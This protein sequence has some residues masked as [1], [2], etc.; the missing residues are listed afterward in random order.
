MKQIRHLLITGIIVAGLT[1][2]IGILLQMVIDRMPLGGSVQADNIESLLLKHFWAIAFLFALIVGIMLYSIFAFRQ[3]KGE[4]E[5]GDYLEGNTPLELVWTIVPTGVVIWFAFLGGQSLTLMEAV[6]RD[7]LRV[8]VTARQWSWS[9]EYPEHG[10]TSDVLVLPI[11]DQTL[12]R[13]R[14][15]DVVHSFWVPEFGPKQD[16]LP[17]GE[18]RELRINPTVAGEYTLACAELCGRQHALMLARVEVMSRT[19][20]DAWVEMKVA[21]D[22]CALGDQVGCGQKLSQESG[23]Q[24]CHTVDGSP[25]VGPTWLGLYETEE[26]MSDGEMVMADQAYLIQSIREPGAHIVMGFENVMPIAISD[27]L[28]DEDVL[29]IIAYIESLR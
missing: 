3:K 25:S 10:I 19:D 22:P 11:D 1:A 28:T 20:F 5:D 16:L 29:A 15:T 8:N 14:S 9:F 6:D 21:E 27:N 26:M 23:C 24:A 12:L 13:L 18:V 2:G 7:A 17:G 4:L